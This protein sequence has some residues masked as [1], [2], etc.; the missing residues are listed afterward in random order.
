[1]ASSHP[2]FHFPIFFCASLTLFLDAGA[3]EACIDFV[4]DQ[5]CASGHAGGQGDFSLL[6][7]AVTSK[8]KSS[9][10]RQSK[11]IQIWTDNEDYRPV[12]RHFLSNHPDGVEDTLQR[13]SLS[14][15][16][17]AWEAAKASGLQADDARLHLIE[18]FFQ[19]KPA[20]IRNI[21]AELNW[22][23]T[24][25]WEAEPLRARLADVEFAEYGFGYAGPHS[26]NAG[27]YHIS[28]PRMVTL[29]QYMDQEKFG[30]N[31]ILFLNEPWDSYT[32]PGEMDTIHMLSDDWSPRPAFAFG[33]ETHNSTL[34]FPETVAN[35]HGFHFHSA[36]FHTQVVG[37]K[38]WYL[39]PP[40]ED[41][42]SGEQGLRKDDG[43]YEY[44][45]NACTYLD[46]MSGPPPNGTL[47]YFA[48][49]G[50]T[51]VLPKN[52]WHGTCALDEW[53]MGT[54]GW[55]QA[56]HVDEQLKASRLEQGW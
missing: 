8:A 4:Q 51:V 36:V 21:P 30:G 7:S 50:D 16:N 14:S 35:G 19:N 46:P 42:E 25:L 6:Q 3:L 5:P 37:R 20:I 15:V 53:T 23:A 27:N 17:E 52:W 47:S 22:K 45:S 2:A 56:Q 1:M 26:G 39:H 10:K 28:P 11:P 49:P 54:G 12:A 33:A 38:M 29:D 43:S 24:K 13:F 41:Q 44:A 34:M 18:V 9:T 31:H 48:M 40:L 55:L 32:H